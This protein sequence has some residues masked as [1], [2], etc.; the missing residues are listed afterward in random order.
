MWEIRIASPRAVFKIIL[1][2]QQCDLRVQ[3]LLEEV[4]CPVGQTDD[5]WSARRILTSF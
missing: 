3:C 4:D 1:L 2:H 5:Y